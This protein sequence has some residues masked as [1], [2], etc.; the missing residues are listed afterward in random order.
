MKPHILFCCL[1]I[2]L[3]SCT[4]NNSLTENI[5]INSAPGISTDSTSNTNFIFD[6]DRITILH[7]NEVSKNGRE[8]NLSETEL[9]NCAIFLEKAIAEFNNPT[10]LPTAPEKQ[11]QLEK[12]KMQ[13]IP[14]INSAG[15]KVV[16]IQCFCQEIDKSNYWKTNVL[17]IS[18]GGHCVFGL[19]INLT[20]K[21]FTPVGV[22]GH[23]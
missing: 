21:T 4:Q 14:F 15:D 18:D 7:N 12:Y 17:L 3:F 2:V 20:R 11:I 8:T 16:H 10:S 19:E 6:T 22:H 1:F 5:R 13:Y 23:A 9:K